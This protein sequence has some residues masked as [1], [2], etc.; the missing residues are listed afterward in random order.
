MLWLAGLGCM[1]A[2]KAQWY[3]QSHKNHKQ[4]GRGLLDLANKN[5]RCPVKF[6]LQINNEYCVSMSY[7]ML[8]TGASLVEKSTCNVGDLGLVPGLGRSPGGGHDNPLQYSCLEESPWWGILGGYRELDMTERLSTTHSVGDIFTLTYY[9][10]FLL[11]SDLTRSSILIW[12]F[13]RGCFDKGKIG[14]P[15]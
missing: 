12:Q 8:G 11:N 3:S 15:L 9:S 5:S 10:L 2:P 6:E 14:M 4:R 7:S 1:P 13:Q